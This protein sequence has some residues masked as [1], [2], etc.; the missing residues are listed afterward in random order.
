[1]TS[2][3]KSK[4]GAYA[5][6]LAVATAIT[7]GTTIT[8]GVASASPRPAASASMHAKT[9]KATARKV[10]HPARVS[11]KAESGAEKPETG[12]EKPEVSTK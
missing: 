4:K 9:K 1:M 5:A 2:R 6:A 8:A 3:T 12:A 7:A 11:G 10:K